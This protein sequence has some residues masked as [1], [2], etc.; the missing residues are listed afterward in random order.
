MWTT[1]GSNLEKCGGA[2][3]CAAPP[4]GTPNLAADGPYTG[5]LRD[6]TFTD[7]ARQFVYAG[8]IPAA[9]L[10]PNGYSAGDLVPMRGC[11]YK[12]SFSALLTGAAVQPNPAAAG[13]TA[14]TT[15]YFH[16]E[17]LRLD[18]MYN[19]ALG[20]RENRIHVDHTVTSAWT[21]G[22]TTNGQSGNERTLAENF[23][24][25]GEEINFYPGWGAF[26]WVSSGHLNLLWDQAYSAAGYVD[27]YYGCSAVADPLTGACTTTIASGAAVRNRDV[28]KT[29][30]PLFAAA[31]DMRLDRVAISTCDQ[32]PL[33][34]NGPFGSAGGAAWYN[35]QTATLA[36]GCA[37]WG[38]SNADWSARRT[39]W[40]THHTFSVTWMWYIFG[41]H[42]NMLWYLKGRPD[43]TI[44]QGT[45][46]GAKW[47]A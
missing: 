33:K 39:A 13:A 38:S 31:A 3:A 36:A 9:Q 2:A 23:N 19:A 40:L 14:A 30:Q 16:V 41:N 22:G 26:Y 7:T 11:L 8:S 27:G 34:W 15:K 10:G 6:A 46:V 1:A 43:R 28:C 45:G 37:A 24:E 25:N 5:D 20:I 42:Y 44:A 35:A 18:I 29:G 4:A 12:L 47:W 32:W 21:A 17:R